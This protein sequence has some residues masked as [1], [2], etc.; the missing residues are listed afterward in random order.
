MRPTVPLS[1]VYLFGSRNDTWKTSN[2]RKVYINVLFNHKYSANQLFIFYPSHNAERMSLSSGKYVVTSLLGNRFVGRSIA[3]T[4][5]LDPKPVFALPEGS[6]A[7]LVSP[8][9]V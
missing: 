3:E 8:S 9:P 4:T 2:T 6:I 7:P 5:G 1:D